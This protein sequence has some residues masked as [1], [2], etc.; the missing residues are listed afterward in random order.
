MFVSRSKFNFFSSFAYTTALGFSPI[1]LLFP[2]VFLFSFLGSLRLDKSQVLLSS[3]ILVWFFL[4]SL[5]IFGGD[6][7]TD[8]TMKYFLGIFLNCLFW[9]SG[10][11]APIQA[12]NSRWSDFFVVFII[13]VDTVFRFA[14]PSEMVSDIYRFKENSFLFEDSNFVGFFLLF[15]AIFRDQV[16]GA[17]SV[18]FDF[19]VF[20]LLFLTFSRAALFVFCF[21]VLVRKISLFGLFLGG[22]LLSIV[23]F[24]L[25]FFYDNFVLEII[26]AGSFKINNSTSILT[27]YFQDISFISFLLGR[28]LGWSSSVTGYSAHIYFVELLVEQGI[29]AIAFWS[30]AF[31]LSFFT[32]SKGV[33]IFV[34]HFIMISFSFAPIVAPYLFFFLGSLYKARN[35]ERFL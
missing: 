18:K 6:F 9:F 13:G 11:V 22:A 21:Y 30:L 12:F 31:L 32:R 26:L 25:F 15:F 7:S 10:C 29:F 2:F 14:F 5:N 3:I 20:I 23:T 34:L 33:F 4:V 35:A 1:Y 8:Y 24:G 19:L 27:S 17:V 28:G 16:R